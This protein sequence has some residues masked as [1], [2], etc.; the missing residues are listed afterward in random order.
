RR[1]PDPGPTDPAGEPPRASQPVAVVPVLLPAPV[2]LFRAALVP[3]VGGQPHHVALVDVVRRGVDDV[4]R[5]HHDV[6]GAV[7]G[8]QPAGVAAAGAGG[9]RPAAAARTR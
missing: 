8:G 4:R 3:D 1:L 6:A 2:D 7:V 5:V 9:R